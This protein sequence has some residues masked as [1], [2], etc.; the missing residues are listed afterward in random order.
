MYA[1][2]LD[3]INV[4]KQPRLRLPQAAAADLESGTDLNP[5][6]GAPSTL[7]VQFSA[8]TKIFLFV[9]RQ[10]FHV[11]ETP[12]FARTVMLAEMYKIFE[13]SRNWKQAF[14]FIFTTQRKKSVVKILVPATIVFAETS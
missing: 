11:C 3:P 13:F 7:Q 2:E 1:P 5:S 12:P 4:Q 14:S 8:E 9:S 6:I 10:K